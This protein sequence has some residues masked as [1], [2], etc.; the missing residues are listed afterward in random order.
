MNAHGFGIVLFWYSEDNYQL[1]D[2]FIEG[3]L[4]LWLKLHTVLYS[5]Y[6][7]IVDS[8]WSNT[9]YGPKNITDWLVS[10]SIHRNTHNSLTNCYTFSININVPQRT[11]PKLFC[12]LL[13][14]IRPFFFICTQKLLKSNIVMK[15][16]EH[17][18]A[19]KL[20]NHF[21][22]IQ[23]HVACRCSSSLADYQ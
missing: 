7:S 23:Q 8:Q 4:N 5:Q 15:F 9:C 19:P 3:V 18:H 2:F 10:L 6:L 13:T 12:D 22:A 21:H 16:V 17:I 11:N 1:L 20:M 14:S